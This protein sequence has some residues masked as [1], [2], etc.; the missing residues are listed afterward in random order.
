[1]G[2]DLPRYSGNAAMASPKHGGEQVWIMS[3][4]TGEENWFLDYWGGV[5]T[6]TGQGGDGGGV[7][8]G[9]TLCRIED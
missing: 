8:C 9:R 6:L 3:L 5:M 4:S 1:M 7:E 2:L